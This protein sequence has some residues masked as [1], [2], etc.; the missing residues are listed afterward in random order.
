MCVC[1]WIAR[2]TMAKSQN[3][4]DA[5]RREQKKKVRLWLHVETFSMLPPYRWSL[6][7]ALS[8]IAC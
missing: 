4:M 8:S 6:N 2:V 7:H 1:V 5:F 3:P